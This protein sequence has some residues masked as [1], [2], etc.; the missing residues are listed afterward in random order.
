M[1]KIFILLFYLIVNLFLVLFWIRQ[2]KTQT[3]CLYQKTV[4]TFLICQFLF[5]FFTYNN[6]IQVLM[7][8][9][10]EFYL[11]FNSM[12][13]I[14]SQDIFCFTHYP[15]FA[16][17]ICYLIISGF[18]FKQI[19]WILLINGILH[20]L[21][22]RGKYGIGD[23]KVLFIISLFYKYSGPEINY[24]LYSC[25]HILAALFLF[26]ILNLVRKNIT[27][28]LKLKK[29]MEFVPSIALTTWMFL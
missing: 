17:G 11:M 19:I 7:L 5:Y 25:F 3:M 8:S 26:T 27:K 10:L 23:S 4:A 21:I 1:I 14:Y 22:L 16:I 24:I 13:D 29:E 15:L 18:S 20:F 9:C 2:C 28:G 6:L 12:S